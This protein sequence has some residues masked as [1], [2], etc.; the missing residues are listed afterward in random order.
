MTILNGMQN[1]VKHLYIYKNNEP[2]SNKLFM[3]IIKYIFTH[4]NNEVVFFYHKI[5]QV[6]IC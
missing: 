1:F 4:A 6:S 2:I 3:Y 5:R